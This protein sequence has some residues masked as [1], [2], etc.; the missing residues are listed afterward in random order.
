MT[1]DQ[2]SNLLSLHSMARD[3]C[4]E[5][6]RLLHKADPI[7]YDCATFLQEGELPLITV[8]NE[9]I[10]AESSRWGGTIT[11]M[12]PI[13]YLTMSDDEILR[14]LKSGTSEFDEHGLS[15]DDYTHDISFQNSI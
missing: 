5:L 15:K 2:I 1:L 13:A 12:I 8:S 14:E 9:Y 3:R 7:L 6:V 11:D 10:Y 4:G